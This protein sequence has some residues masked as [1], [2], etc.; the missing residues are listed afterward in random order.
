MIKMLSKPFEIEDT[1]T[2]EEREAQRIDDFAKCHKRIVD[3]MDEFKELNMNDV[4]RRTRF[5]LEKS[6]PD[7]VETLEMI[8]ESAR[9]SK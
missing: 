7:A 3:L 1:R 9:K 5:I 2:P 6:F 8:C 4:D